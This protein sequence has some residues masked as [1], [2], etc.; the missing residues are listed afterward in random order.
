MKRRHPKVVVLSYDEACEWLEGCDGKEPLAIVSIGEPGTSPP[1]GFKGHKARLRL[2]CHDTELEDLGP[3][4][5]DVWAT[6][7]FARQIAQ[8]P[9]TVL[10]HCHAGVS[11]SAAA[12]VPPGNQA[13]VM[14]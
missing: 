3:S 10:V 2:E 9:G 4:A 12:V 5:H 7:E 8:H 13:N 6:V 11:R 1:S 14:V